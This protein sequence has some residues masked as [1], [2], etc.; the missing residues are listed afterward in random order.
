MLF[1]T[2]T[3]LLAVLALVGSGL[4]IA[5]DGSDTA[6]LNE[7]NTSERNV[8]DHVV[9]PGATTSV[10]VSFKFQ[11]A[12]QVTLVETFTPE[13]GN[14]TIVDTGGATLSGVNNANDELFVDW[15]EVKTA[16]VTYE[17]TVPDDAADGDTFTLNSGKMSDVTIEPAV[18]E[19]DTDPAFFD[20][21]ELTPGETSID[22]GDS[23]N[24]SATVTNT[25]GTTDTQAVNL[26]LDGEVVASQSVTLEP[27]ETQSVT[28]MAALGDRDAGS[29]EYAVASAD[30]AATVT[31]T[32]GNPT[33]D[34]DR[35][36]SE[37]TL[38]P[39]AT[40]TVTV[41]VTQNTSS[42]LFLAE[43]FTPAFA[44]VTIVD[45]GGADFKGVNNANDE[46]FAD[47]GDVK[48]TTLTYK[49][50]IP[51]DATAGDEYTIQ[52][53]SSSDYAL[54]TDTITI[55]DAEPASFAVEAFD[56][57]G[58]VPQEEN[59]TVNA[60]VTNVGG[61]NG[62][63]TVEYRLGGDVVAT[64]TVTLA[65]NETVTVT[66]E[67]AAT[68][69]RPG[70][71]THG[72]WIAEESHTQTLTVKHSRATYAGDNG[73]IGLRGVS[74]ASTDWNDG[75]I[76]LSLLRDIIGHWRTDTPVR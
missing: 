9:S 39:G 42:G 56:A 53:A 5:A 61:M 17:V 65:P 2:V 54:G 74:N 38:T 62:T 73:E 15:G 3:L 71:V 14:V 52:S 75:H 36:I 66:F 47:W 72:V 13:F 10:T 12:R 50:T 33:A 44:D 64:E 1:V 40:T 27:G 63:E 24:V 29:Y 18:I 28:F 25:G 69:D 57:P 58:S 26:T 22:S 67:A 48:S 4:G 35:T 21:A 49:V 43:S 37:S 60:T 7:T 46:V 70:A 11:E 59:I 51:K 16:T 30:E 31:L 41:D 8:S 32:V 23:V 20:V 19:V 45:D 76:D 55:S 34:L 68:T 6:S